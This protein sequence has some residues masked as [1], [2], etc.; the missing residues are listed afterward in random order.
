MDS[1]DVDSDKVAGVECWELPGQ[2]LLLKISAGTVTEKEVQD[3][4]LD[5]RG[6]VIIIYSKIDSVQTRLTDF[7][8]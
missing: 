3:Y 2:A 1:V 5:V 7:E 6:V 8:E 4:L